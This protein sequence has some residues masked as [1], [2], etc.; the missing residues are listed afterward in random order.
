MTAGLTVPSLPSRRSANV[1]R[2][3][4]VA[5]SVAMASFK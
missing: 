2:T 3:L 1:L 4:S 5:L